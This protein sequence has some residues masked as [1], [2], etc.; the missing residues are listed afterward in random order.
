MFRQIFRARRLPPSS[1]FRRQ[2][3]T[4]AIYSSFPATLHYYSPQRSSSLYERKESGSPPEDIFDEGV[5]LK[6]GLVYPAVDKSV[7]NGAVMFPNTFLM[8]EIVRMYFDETLDRED[9]GKNVETPFIYTIPR[10]TPVPSHLILINEYLCRFSLQPSRGIPLE[11]LNR[12]LDEF[13]LKHGS[14]ETAESWLDRHPFQEAVPDE[15]DDVW[16]AK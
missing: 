16:M 11:Y 2:F 12:S 8:Q 14:K 7:S 4:K 1:P 15:A 10:G 9:E 13:Y 3:S 5:T 6:H